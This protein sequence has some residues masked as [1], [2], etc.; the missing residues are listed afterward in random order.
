MY[1]LATDRQRYND[2]RW[3]TCAVWL[4]RKLMHFFVL[5][6]WRLRFV[7]HVVGVLHV[8][9]LRDGIYNVLSISSLGNQ[10]IQSNK[11]WDLLKGSDDDRSVS[12]DLCFCTFWVIFLFAMCCRLH[13]I[14]PPY[15]SETILSSFFTCQFVV[16]ARKCI[17]YLKCSKSLNFCLVCTMN[18]GYAF[19]MIYK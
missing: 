16:G 5:L 10:Y 9:R 1:C 14:V 11:P 12:I 4:A 19:I 6:V 2:N 8:C 7:C 18:P 13:G 15:L 3:Y 17:R